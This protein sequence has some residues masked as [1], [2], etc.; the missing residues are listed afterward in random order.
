[1]AQLSS[2]SVAEPRCGGN[3]S[4]VSESIQA[5][6]HRIL[7][8]VPEGDEARTTGSKPLTSSPAQHPR[9]AL[10]PELEFD[11]AGTAVRRVNSLQLSS[12]DYAHNHNPLRKTTSAPATQAPTAPIRHDTVSLEAQDKDGSVSNFVYTDVNFFPLCVT[13]M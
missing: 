11:R 12:T 8:S 13:D 4:R 9:S 10:S 1:M 6:S 7:H 2:I 5:P 3:D